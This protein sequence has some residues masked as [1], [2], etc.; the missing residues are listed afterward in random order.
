MIENS[1]NPLSLE[2]CVNYLDQDNLKVS[3]SLMLFLCMCVSTQ[4]K[5]DRGQFVF[6]LFRKKMGKKQIFLEKQVR[7]FATSSKELLETQ[8]PRGLMSLSMEENKLDQL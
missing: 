4:D 5:S 8:T 3:P 6:P 2:D 1:S 7:L